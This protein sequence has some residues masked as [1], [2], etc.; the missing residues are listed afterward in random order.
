MKVRF[1]FMKYRKLAGLI[2]IALV[3]AG[4]ASLATKGLNYG[5]DFAGG[6]SMDVRS[7]SADYG[8]ADMRRDL[9][10]FRPELQE[11]NQGNVMIR[12]GLDINATDEQQN[13]VVREINQILGER[14]TFLQ[15][16]VVGP[17]I[18]SELIRGGML[19]IIFAFLMMSIY[20]WIRYRGGYAVGMLTSLTL[21]F[22]LI[23]GFFSI[24]GLE[25]SQAAIAVILMG[26]GY[27]TNDKIV[28]YDRIAENSKKY[29]KMPT[30]DLIDLSVNEMLSR[31]ILTSVTTLLVMAALWLF[32]GN[33]L[34]E[35]AIA[36][37]FSVIMGSLT[38]IFVS[39]T[40]LVYFKIRDT[41]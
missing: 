30:L 10:E 22:F 37:S 17:K 27:S 7:N 40:V 16:Q 19:A 39:N 15:T 3:L 14:V 12:I 41:D 36:M 31:T 32:A 21:D 38:S 18:G 5:I 8:I 9:A 11:D 23:F 2:S 34:G 24:V 13:I 29:H 4:F 33:V 1:H 35:F 26:V 20:V 28:N 6:I 25:F